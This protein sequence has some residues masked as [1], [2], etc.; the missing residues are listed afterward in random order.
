MIPA[1]ASCYP[2]ESKGTVCR[3]WQVPSAQAAALLEVGQRSGDACLGRCVL[4]Q[5]QWLNVLLVG[6]LRGLVKA[7]PCREL[8]LEP[9]STRPGSHGLSMRGL[10]ARKGTERAAERVV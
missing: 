10:E 5:W 1:D 6:P 3:G 7:W 4:G 8:N 2:P 9:E